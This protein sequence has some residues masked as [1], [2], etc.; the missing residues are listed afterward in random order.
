MKARE[1]SKSIFPPS[2][3]RAEKEKIGVDYGFCTAIRSIPERIKLQHLKIAAITSA[4]FVLI[5]PTIAFPQ[6]TV[7]AERK[8]V[9][10]A[11]GETAIEDLVIGEVG[12]VGYL[13][14]CTRDKILYIPSNFT[15]TE[16]PA[17]Y[18]H[19]YR[20]KRLQNEAVEIESVTADE[21]ENPKKPMAL[22]L[23]LSGI[24]RDCSSTE[25]SNIQMLQVK[26]IDGAASAAELVAKYETENEPKPE[27]E[28]PAK[29]YPQ[30]TTLTPEWSITEESALLDDSKKV[31]GLLLPVS[32]SS[33]GVGSSSV[34]LAIRCE[35]NTT[36]F[37]I[38]TDMFMTSDQPEVI[39]RLG[40]AP[41]ETQ[42][43]TRSS[44]YK[45]VGLWTGPTA[46]PFIKK[47]TNNE[48]LYVRLR[49]K[50]R[51]E[52]Q[53][54]LSNVDDVIKKVRSACNW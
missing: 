21:L 35:E 46:I 37:I 31:S 4:L 6:F 50:D 40:A 45:A 14:S 51:V 26:S 15:I 1:K 53:F 32:N 10:R 42:R 33:T 30:S 11:M 24:E 48:K 36:S 34:Y 44:D 25:L 5:T 8:E 22:D 52:A 16:G 19:S 47:L 41:A 18:G 54:N 27:V 17:K 39:F 49:D 28:R 20:V 7:D 3:S 43:W 29:Q 38:I 23:V 13:S 2:L 12:I 9:R